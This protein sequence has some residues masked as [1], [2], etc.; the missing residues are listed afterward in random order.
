V[1]LPS[2]GN[3]SGIRYKNCAKDAEVSFYTIQGGGHSWP[4]GGYLPEFLV[5][6]TTQ[7]MDATR[8]MWNFFEEHTLESQK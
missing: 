8:V 6:A 3:A 1:D 7:D 4:G 5:G 2:S